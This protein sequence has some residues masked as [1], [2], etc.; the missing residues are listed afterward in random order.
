MPAKIYHD[1]SQFV[2]NKK[3][4]HLPISSYINNQLRGITFV[5]VYKFLVA[6]LMI[7]A[8]LNKSAHAIDAFTDDLESFRETFKLRGNQNC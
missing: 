3:Q 2:C 5:L 6:D 1:P 7:V 8:S 4:L